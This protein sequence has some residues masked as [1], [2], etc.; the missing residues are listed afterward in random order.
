MSKDDTRDY[1]T[2]L[3][4]LYLEFMLALPSDFTRCQNILKHTY[5][6]PKLQSTIKFIMDYADAYRHLPT[7]EQVKG[8]TGY[9]LGKINEVEAGQH[10]Q[11][12]LQSI[13]DFCRHKAMEALVLE[14]PDLI[15]NGQY[16][17]LER[18]SK[19]NMMISLQKDMGTDYFSDPLA[20]LTAM[21]D[22]KNTISTGW[23]GI[24]KKLYGGIGRGELMIFAGGPGTGKSLFLQNIALNWVQAGLNVVYITLELSEDLVAMRFDAMISETGT[25]S[26][27][28]DLDNVASKV[29]MQYKRNKWGSLRIK[30]LPEA[31]TSAN[32]I[33]AFLKEYEIQYGFK[34]DALVIDYLDLLHPNSGKI[35]AADLFIKDKYTSEEMRAMSAEWNTLT[36]TASQLNRASTQ[37]ADFDHSH[38]A[39]GIS[40]INTA[41]NV[42]GIFRS[43]SMMDQGMYQIQF[44]KTRS[45]S[46]VGSRVDLRFNPETLR[47]VDVEEN[48]QESYTP[49]NHSQRIADEVKAAPQKGSIQPPAAVPPQSNNVSTNSRVTSI[50]DLVSKQ[51]RL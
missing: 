44:L 51:K 38:I 6:T 33:R 26:I 29:A 45:S 11:W 22:R 2:D 9:T 15:S 36:V 39:G 41:D 18:R 27:F 23:A 17:E 47:I 34:P 16:A 32:D 21:K 42:L 19:E 35:S 43:S 1:N 50:M 7:T 5:W 14:G 20:R 25:K 12:F 13:E 8:E 10:S 46:G 49:S 24:D 3:Q 37:V 40:K 30:K 31:G 28:K 4:Q 48:E